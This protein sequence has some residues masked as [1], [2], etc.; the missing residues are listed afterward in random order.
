MTPREL[1]SPLRS[2]TGGVKTVEAGAIT[3]DLELRTVS[4]SGGVAATVR[5]ATAAEWYAVAGSPVDPAALP[6]PAHPA[7]HELIL[8][9]LT[10]PGPTENG[11]EAPVGL[12]E[13]RAGRR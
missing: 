10:A 7:V 8:R 9:H 4:V 3:G 6:D 13:D 12:D 1:R 5:Y 11:N 2:T